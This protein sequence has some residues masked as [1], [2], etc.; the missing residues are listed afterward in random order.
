MALNISEVE[1]HKY[2][3]VLLMLMSLMGL[4]ARDPTGK[5]SEQILQALLFQLETQG[6]L[7][8]WAGSEPLPEVILLHMELMNAWV[9]EGSRRVCWGSGDGFVHCWALFGLSD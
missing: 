1:S 5:K 4:K 7:W 2:V 8:Q 6:S 3:E 9:S